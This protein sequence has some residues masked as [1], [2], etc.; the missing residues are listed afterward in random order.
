M[1]DFWEYLLLFAFLVVGTYYYYQL[2][3]SNKIAKFVMILEVGIK[4]WILIWYLDYGGGYSL[5]E[6]IFFAPIIL[7]VALYLSNGWVAKI[8]LVVLVSFV[9]I[10]VLYLAFI[11]YINTYWR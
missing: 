3:L 4:T 5:L 2:Y 1:D 6:Y 8:L 10:D 11:P 9:V 7:S